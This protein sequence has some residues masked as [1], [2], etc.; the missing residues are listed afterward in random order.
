MLKL[1]RK[2]RF[3]KR[4]LKATCTYLQALQVIFPQTILIDSRWRDP[5]TAD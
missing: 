5:L 4:F 1:D 2:R 3:P